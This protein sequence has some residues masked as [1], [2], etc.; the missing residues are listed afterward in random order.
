MPLRVIV[1][2]FMMVQASHLRRTSRF[3]PRSIPRAG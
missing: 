2:F 1:T 3:L